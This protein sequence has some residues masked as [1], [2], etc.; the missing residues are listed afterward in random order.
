[1]ARIFHDEELLAALRSVAAG[2]VIVNGEG[3]V[4]FVNLAAEGMT[5]LDDEGAAGKPF[6]DILRMNS[7]AEADDLA[8]RVRCAIAGDALE[9]G[10]LGGTLKGAKGVA[11]PVECTVRAIAGAPGKLGGAVIVLRDVTERRQ[12]EEALLASERKYRGLFENSIEGIFQ[13]TLEGRLVAANPQLARYFGYATPEEFLSGE[14]NDT[15]ELYA[16][17][18]TRLELLRRLSGEGKVEHFEFQSKGRAGAPGRWFSMNARAVRDAHGN[19]SGIEGT[20]LEIT[21][22]KRA[23]EALKAREACLRAIMDSS[24]YRVWLKDTTGV[25]LDLN[26]RLV[27]ETGRSSAEEVRGKTDFDL[28]PEEEARR[29]RAADEEAMRSGGRLFHEEAVDRQGRRHYIEKFKSPIRD[30]AGN[31]IGICGFSRDVTDARGS[32]ELIR[33]LSRVVDQSPSTI[34]IT[35]TEGTIEY[36]N[37]RFTALTGYAPEEAVGKNPRILNAGKLPKEVYEGLWKTLAGGN[38]WSGELLNRKKNGELF[39]EYATIAPVRDD[40]GTVTHYVAIKEDIT[41]RKEA[42]S[43]LARRAEDLLQA[44]SRA[45]QQAIRLGVQAF[46]LRKAREDALRASKLKSEFVANM[47]H[48]I[49]TPMNG[50]LGMAGLLLDTELTAE[51][52]EYAEIIRTSGQA[53]LG[54]VNDILD[55]SKIEAGKLDLETIDFD[56]RTTIDESIDLVAAG[57]RNKGLDVHFGIDE[58]VPTSLR[59][60]PGRLRQVLTNLLSNAVKFTERG[61]VALSVR[62][63][64]SEGPVTP[65]TIVIRDTGIGIS[66]EELPRLFKSFSQADGST[67]R[68]HGGTGLGLVIA[69]QLVEMMGGEIGVRSEK[70]KGSEFWFTVR[71]LAQSAPQAIPPA[72]VAAIKKSGRPERLRRVLV[73][74]DNQVNQRVALRMLEKLGCRA[75]VVANGKEAVEAVARLPYDLILMDC[76]MPVMDGFEATATIRKLNGRA[77]E[78]LVVALTASALQGDRERCMK[79][80]MN[81]YL[82]KPVTQ[83]SLE[84]LLAKWDLA[85][86]ETGEHSPDEGEARSSEEG[87]DPEKVAELRELGGDSGPG[88]LESL[89]EHFMLDASGR[90]GKLREALAGGDARAFE[91]VAHALKGSCATLGVTPM[92]AIAERLQAMGR[93]GSLAGAAPLIA[94]LERA[95]AEAE[96]RLERAL[97]GKDGAR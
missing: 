63:G 80:G 68:K 83:E 69:K 7:S 34:V 4:T 65:L 22:R 27:E 46:E 8:R 97:F 35:D 79:A 18:G 91:E 42:E 64:A 67:T 9:R 58:G 74:E 19:V 37:P 14:G 12:A 59:G 88:W 2:I 82:P 94:D 90:V 93:A 31:V 51:Q 29:I 30:A 5:G 13:S 55:F 71:L 39:W 66:E 52:R 38:E 81:D 86:S 11:L 78:T 57:A 76:Q 56:L 24:P 53:L 61:E 10:P 20:L 45:E 60:D 23:L 72:D 84:R 40:R 44:K 62:A 85:L 49:R 26:S 73:A 1:M 25:Y 92:R 32:E 3:L 43:E 50:V 95:M 36:V 41:K 28:Y 15:A 16:D 87:L 6:A 47:S 33:K 54:I 89:L 70:G 21:E 77:A 17:P 48:E 75:D 96:P